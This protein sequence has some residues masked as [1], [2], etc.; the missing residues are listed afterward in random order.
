[1]PETKIK[2]SIESRL[3]G[4]QSKFDLHNSHEKQKL[5]VI[6]LKRGKTRKYKTYRMLKH[7]AITNIQYFPTWLI[8]GLRQKKYLVSS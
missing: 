4:N 5:H 6:F 1:M 2:S 3:A 7:L 8:F